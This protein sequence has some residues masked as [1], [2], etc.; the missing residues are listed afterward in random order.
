MRASSVESRFA[1][2]RTTATPLVGG[3]EET[4]LLMRRWEQA[5]AADGCVVLI[6]GEPGIGNSRIAETTV[7]VLGS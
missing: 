6:S 2:L 3:E 4:A 7:G 5:K 1:A